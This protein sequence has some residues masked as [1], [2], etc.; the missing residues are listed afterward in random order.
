MW[1]KYDYF[2]LHEVHSLDFEKS[3]PKSYEYY[4]W[5]QKLRIQIMRVSGQNKN[6]R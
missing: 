2:P 6:N 4:I 1:I 3:I 5:E